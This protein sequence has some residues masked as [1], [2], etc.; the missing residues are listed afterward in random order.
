MGVLSGVAKPDH[1]AGNRGIAPF[2]EN[3]AGH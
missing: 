1:K 3:A 2:F